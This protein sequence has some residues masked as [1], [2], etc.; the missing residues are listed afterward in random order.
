MPT[1][2]VNGTELWCQVQGEGDPILLLPG[3]GLDHNYYRF[4]EPEGRPAN[5]WAINN[6]SIKG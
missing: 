5:G 3:L 2:S 1:A 6:A 4:G